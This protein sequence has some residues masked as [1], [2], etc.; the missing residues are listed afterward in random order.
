[1]NI[2]RL[3]ALL[4]VA[5]IICPSAFSQEKKP[6]LALA[7]EMTSDFEIHENG[8]SRRETKTSVDTWIIDLTQKTA[9]NGAGFETDADISDEFIKF[10]W[11]REMKVVGGKSSIDAQVTISRI[12]GRIQERRASRTET[13]FMRKELKIITS[14]GDG[15]CTESKKF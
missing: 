2:T 11:K 5:S 14:T 10:A 15:V 13:D 3:L 4:L 1:M 9:S 8:A 6:R 12:T 7:C